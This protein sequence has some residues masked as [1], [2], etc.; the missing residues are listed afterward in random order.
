MSEPTW[1]WAGSRVVTDHALEV[2]IE[3]Q[4]ATAP[5]DSLAWL[6]DVAGAQRPAPPA[7]WHPW[8]L[9]PAPRGHLPADA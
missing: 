3:K 1:R 2:T 4:D 9:P 7:P 5:I 8:V 6:L